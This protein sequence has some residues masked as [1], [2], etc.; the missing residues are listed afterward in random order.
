MSAAPAATATPAVTITPVAAPTELLA[1][2]Q[3]DRW[4][5]RLS[6]GFRRVAATLT[7]GGRPLAGQLI[8]FSAGSLVLCTATTDGDGVAACRLSLWAELRVLFTNH[9]TAAFAGNAG[10]VASVDSTPTFIF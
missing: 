10:Y 8:T 7:S 4:A 9:Y 1:Q 6:A 3:L 2:P 5:P